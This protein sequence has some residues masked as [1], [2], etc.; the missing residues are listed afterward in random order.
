M[1][2]VHRGK[3]PSMAYVSDSYQHIKVIINHPYP[4]NRF[5][6]VVAYVFKSDDSSPGIGLVV[7]WEPQTGL[8]RRHSHCCSLYT[9]HQIMKRLV[10]LASHFNNTNLHL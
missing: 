1:R 2:V 8:G 9:L 6:C 5:I 7:K 10:T 3:N 4:C